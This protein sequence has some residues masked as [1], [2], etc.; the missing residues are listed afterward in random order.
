MMRTYPARTSERASRK[1][2]HV[3]PTRSRQLRRG[4]HRAAFTLMETALAIVIVGTGVIS[5]MQAQ[6]AFHQQNSWS[7]HTS[8]ATFLANEIR[9]MTV[10]LPRHDPVTG[11]TFWGPEP[12]ESSVVD[13]DDLDDFDGEFGIGV[14]FS[15]AAG[16]GPVNALREEIPDMAGWSQVVR[17]YNVDPMDMGAEG[18]DAMDGTTN[19]VRMEVTITYQGPNDADPTEITKLVWISR[20]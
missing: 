13:F 15:E 5:I 12:N 10:R 20:N 19:M 14:V 4:H 1:T 3:S 6:M 7:S 17:C 9:E 16:N 2:A 18:D 8:A 11:T